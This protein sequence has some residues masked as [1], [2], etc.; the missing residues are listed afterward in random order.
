MVDQPWAEFVASGR[1][2]VL[3]ASNSTDR[4]GPVTIHAARRRPAR[5]LVVGDSVVVHGDGARSGLRRE[6]ITFT[7]LAPLTGRDPYNGEPLYDENRMADLA[8]GATIAAGE[9]AHVVPV[10]DVTFTDEIS[11]WRTVYRGPTGD[12]DAGRVWLVGH[13]QMRYLDVFPGRYVWLFA[14]VRRIEPDGSASA[15][16]NINMSVSANT[17]GVSA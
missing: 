14:D 2:S 11:G 9:L 5:D 16:T 17:I 6:W 1:L 7:G 3:A 10:E 12:A 4:T 13:D 8:M 15:S